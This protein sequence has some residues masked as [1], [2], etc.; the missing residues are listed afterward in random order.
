[1][2]GRKQRKLRWGSARTAEHGA[3]IWT[4]SSPPFLPTRTTS[5]RRLP[6]SGSRRSPAPYHFRPKA[7]FM[8]AQGNA[9][10]TPWVRGRFSHGRPSA[11]LILGGTNHSE[12]G[13]PFRHVRNHFEVDKFL[14]QSFQYG[15]STRRRLLALG[16][17]KH[18]HSKCNL[19]KL[20]QLR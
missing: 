14:H 6:H 13:A 8:P 16:G 10:A 4:P 3:P 18:F 17:L 12:T 2:N 15:R 20:P 5:G 11:C 19:H 9:Q 1:M 7:C